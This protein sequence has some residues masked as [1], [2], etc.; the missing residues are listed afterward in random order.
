MFLQIQSASGM[1]DWLKELDQTLFFKINGAWT[2]SFFDTV[3]PFVREPTV[4]VP[5]YF[6]LS[7]FVLVNFRVNGWLWIM[8]L[9]LTAMVSDYT[10]SSII[11]EWFPR[12]RPCRDPDIAHQ[13]RFLVSYCPVSSSFVSSHAVN[14]F[15]ISTFIFVTFK[16][17][18][19]KKWALVYIWAVMI[20]YAQVYVGVHFPLDV[21][22]GAIIGI[23]FGYISSMLFNRFFPLPHHFNSKL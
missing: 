6:F 1:P 9:M 11:K 12:L 21:T 7:I 5:F 14:H 13:V 3:L 2:H 23:L 15:A 8:F 18:I 4:W 17:A 10:S 19:S 16:D 20:C 22:A